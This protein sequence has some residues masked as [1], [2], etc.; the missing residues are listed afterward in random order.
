MQVAV[1]NAL[2]SHWWERVHLK[3]GP[4]AL[5]G[6]VVFDMLYKQ[7][8]SPLQIFLNTLVYSFPNVYEIFNEKSVVFFWIPLP[9]LMGKMCDA[10]IE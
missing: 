1:D 6:G 4:L 10:S 9:I 8:V 7:P 5:N 2:S 3:K